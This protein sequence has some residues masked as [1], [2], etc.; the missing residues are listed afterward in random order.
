MFSA[1]VWLNPRIEYLVLFA[2]RRVSAAAAG[3]GSCPLP[4]LWLR[5]SFALD[6]CMDLLLRYYYMLDNGAP[7]GSLAFSVRP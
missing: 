6:F 5:T 2:H 4:V 7:K 1:V 3:D